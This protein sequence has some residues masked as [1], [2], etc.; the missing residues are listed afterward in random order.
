MA[1]DTW[2][3]SWEIR[4]QESFIRIYT[5]KEY[6]ELSMDVMIQCSLENKCKAALWSTLGHHSGGHPGP[7]GRPTNDLSIAIEIRWNFLMLLFITYSAGR[8]KILHTSRQCNCQDVCKMWW[9][10]E[11]ILNQSTPNF[12]GI[13]NSVEILLVGQAPDSQVGTPPV[14]QAAA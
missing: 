10:I 5:Y 2:C 4:S 6:M 1:C 11:H 7:G 9:L 14:S 12:Y 13:S 8:N 3:H